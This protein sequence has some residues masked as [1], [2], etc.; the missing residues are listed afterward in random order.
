[1]MDPAKGRKLVIKKY[2]QLNDS[3]SS[4]ARYWKSFKVCCTITRGLVWFGL[5]WFGLTQPQP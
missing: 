1:M 2:A 3:Q 5:V 4:D